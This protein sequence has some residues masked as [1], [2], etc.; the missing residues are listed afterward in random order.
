M[1]EGRR[2]RSRIAD[3]NIERAELGPDLLEDPANLIGLANVG[4]NQ[5]SVRPE[6]ADLFQRRQRRILIAIV[7]NRDTR[8]FF[9]QFQLVK[10]GIASCC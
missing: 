8:S 4:L 2:L 9:R 7:M 6:V 1:V 3:K 5:K 10:M